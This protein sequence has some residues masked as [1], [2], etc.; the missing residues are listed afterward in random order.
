MGKFDQRSGGRS[1]M[2]MTTGEVIRRIRKSVGMTQTELGA[3]INFSQPAVSGLE[4]GG[5]ASHDVRVLRLVARALGVPLAI[6]VVESDQEADVD[7]RNFFRAGASLSAGAAMM[8]V[9]APASAASAS[10]GKVGASD[11]EAIIDSVNQIHELDLVVGGDRLCRVA[12]NQVRYVEQL[13]DQGSYTEAVGR[14]LTSAAAE[15]M[16]AAGWV[17]YD[18]GRLDEARRYYADAANAANAAGDGIAAAHALGN[19]SCLMASRPGDDAKG[20]PLAVQYAQAG[21]RASLRDGGPKLRALMAIREAEAHGVR[22]DK[23]AMTAAISRAHRAYESTRGHDPDWVYLPEAEFVG[24]IGWAQM[25]LGEH[26]QATSN[27]QAAIESSSAWPRERAAWQVHLAENFTT[28]GDV[29]RA[30][31]LLADN[32]DTIAGLASTRLHQRIDAIANTVRSH[33]RVPEVRDFLARRAA[34]V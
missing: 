10:A 33:A 11:V 23:S 3:L 34:Q 7:R 16:T 8:S 2:Y 29:A 28:S 1:A 32:Y 20:N 24:G 4:R 13:L 26:S 21:A 14:A 27:L 22:G 9:S 31:S 5:P 18:A 25:R 6:L 19:A 17:H 30:C 12:A 15:M